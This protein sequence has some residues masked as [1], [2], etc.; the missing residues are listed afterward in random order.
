VRRDRLCFLECDAAPVV[1]AGSAWAASFQ[2]AGVV[3]AEQ[4][5]M[6]LNG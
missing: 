4:L 3:R 1:G 2:S 6:L 5:E